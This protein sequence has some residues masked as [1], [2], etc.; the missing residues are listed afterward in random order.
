MS[1]KQSAAYRLEERH[2][3]LLAM[4]DDFSKRFERPTSALLHEYI[5]FCRLKAT[6]LRQ[7]KAY[8]FHAYM[9]G[10]FSE[11][12]RT[13]LETLGRHDLIQVHDSQLKVS[14]TGEKLIEKLEEEGKFQSVTA[15]CDKV[16]T[17]PGSPYA[18]SQDIHTYLSNT[19]L[20]EAV[21]LP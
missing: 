16:V 21:S 20:G 7:L 3:I 8:D 18:L 9:R 15:E 6:N 13:D 5:L 4:I 19:P 2:H 1:A 12:L 17:K 14:R 10:P 11:Q